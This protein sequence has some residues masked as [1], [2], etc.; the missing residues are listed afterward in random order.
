MTTKNT[1]IDS[2]Q[3]AN[4]QLS[5]IVSAS[6]GTGKT[7]L[8]TTRIVRLLLQNVT[9]SSILAITF[10]N[11]AAGEMQERINERLKELAAASAVQQKQLLIAMGINPSA[12]TMQTAQELY[13]QLLCSEQSIRIQ[14][15][16]SFCHDIL[17]HFALEAEVPAGFSL[18]AEADLLLEE[19]WDNLD[20]RALRHF[21]SSQ[22]QNKQQQDGEI[23][24]L[25]T[26]LHILF[27][28]FNSL[29]TV[30]Q[31]LFDFVHNRNDWWAYS[32]G[33]AAVSYA[34]QQ[35]KKQ[36]KLKSNP[37]QSIENAQFKADLSQFAANINLIPIS[38]L[39]QQFLDAIAA[40]TT[41][42]SNEQY[43]ALSKLLNQ[44]GEP[45]GNYRGNAHMDK[46]IQG[47]RQAQ[48]ELYSKITAA[49]IEVREFLLRQQCYRLN[50][51]WYLAGNDLLQEYQHLKLRALQLDFNDLEYKTYQLLNH[52]QGADWVQYKLDQRINHF[53]FDEFQD[54]NPTQWQLIKPL[55]EELAAAK[56]ERLRSVFLVGD[57]K[58]SIYSFRRANPMLQQNAGAW[59][60]QNL[61]AKQFFLNKSYRCA[62]PIIELANELFL[63]VYKNN[64]IKSFSHHST[65][66]TSPGLVKILAACCSEQQQQQVSLELRN[67]L[68]Q[69]KYAQQQNNYYREGQQIAREIKN[70][71]AANT[72][73]N[74]GGKSRALNYGDIIILLKNRTHSG[75]YERALSAAN[76]PFHGSQ[77]GTFLDNPEVQDIEDIL[78]IINYPLDNLRLAYVLRCPIFRA[79]EDDLVQLAT[80]EVETKY[81]WQRLAKLVANKRAT[82]SLEHC[83]KLITSWQQLAQN[84]PVHDLLDSIYHQSKI[85]AVYGGQVA[86]TDSQSSMA[87][88]QQFLELSLD[89]ASGRYPS[90]NNF[91]N[92]LQKMRQSGAALD[93]AQFGNQ[94]Q[95]VEIMSIHAAKGLE[96]PM[97]ILADAANTYQAHASNLAMI[98]W[99]VNQDKPANFL[100]ATAKHEFCQLQRE[101][102]RQKQ[103]LQQQ[104]NANLLYVAI[105]R[106]RQIL[107]VSASSNKPQIDHDSWYSL[108][109]R[110][111]AN[112]TDSK[113]QNA[114]A[115]TDQLDM[116]QTLSYGE[117]E[118][119]PPAQAEDS[120][121][122]KQQNADYEATANYD[123]QFWSPVSRAS[124]L[125]RIAP[126]EFATDN[127]NLAGL[128]L[129][130]QHHQPSAIDHKDEQKDKA[131]YGA[132]VHALLERQ[133]PPFYSEQ[134]PAT[135][136]STAAKKLAQQEVTKLLQNPKLE[137]LFLP[138]DN[139]LKEVTIQY[140][141]QAGNKIVYGIIDRVVF[142]Q[143][144][145]YIVDYKSHRLP[146][147][148][149]TS[150]LQTLAQSFA[151]QLQYYAQ[152]LRQHYQKTIVAGIVFTHRGSW[153][154]VLRL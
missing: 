112:L 96:A 105:T 102:A 130:D 25:S 67:P 110:A 61:Q 8:L 60:Q 79:S 49:I 129:Q 24:S 27:A 16:H 106:A 42:S 47:G 69:P 126:G 137:F 44:A 64:G 103:Q 77:R 30:K 143:D 63:N 115:N 114:K 51:A 10:T 78:H 104:E 53:L 37:Y 33:Q 140:P 26:A 113:R 23:D 70:L 135:N 12:K 98:N 71:L 40:A 62:L 74:D 7:W 34:V 149:T 152:G 68:Q 121:Q 32:R 89:F 73:I 17:Q 141:T 57:S 58:Q 35:L 1:T 123:P 76:I 91:L 13:R 144:T 18:N 99:P 39:A 29:Q 146:Q 132:Y 5:A 56:S 134:L 87:N 139:S 128:L 46:K 20:K 2:L 100:L 19:A 107:I 81:W 142:A 109:Y 11:K 150:Q 92:Y 101:I 41:G 54:T 50:C 122:N 127:V 136:L 118:A 52:Q 14:T 38:K 31:C 90:L 124:V 28:H 117:L 131:E 6:A 111:L 145:I 22:Q 45:Y 85:I 65:H 153:H 151:T 119:K 21:A 4:P 43:A 97:V 148:A 95:A 72:Q 59:L 147:Q 93:D 36:L 138:A 9:P 154:E 94:Q 108:L 82:A 84:L 86:A 75:D 3:A 133:S 15:F 66:Q 116:E 80:S 48:L 125:P 83:Y 55:L 120:L 88:L